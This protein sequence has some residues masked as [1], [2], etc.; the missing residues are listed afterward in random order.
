MITVHEPCRKKIIDKR[1]F[2]EKVDDRPK[3]RLRSSY[4]AE[5]VFNWKN[6]CFLCNKKADLRYSTVKKVETL[7]IKT[8]LLECSRERADKWG[9]EVHDRLNSCI[10]LVAEEA[11]Y[12]IVCMN[13]FRL[14]KFA[15][16]K[17]S[18]RPVDETQMENFQKVCQWLDEGDGELYTLAEIY[19]KMI[20]LSE[21]T[22]CY[23]RAYL[24]T[25][26][27]Q[28]YKDH[29]YFIQS[30]GRNDIIGFK[31]MSK[32]FMEE[33]MKMKER[34]PVDMI[35]A[36]AKIIKSDIREMPI[37]KTFYPS[38]IEIRNLDYQAEWV[39]DSL[40]LLLGQLF[41]SKLKQISIGQT[42][43]QASRPRSSIA[44]IPFG[45][46]VNL[47]KSFAT[48]WFVDHLAKFGFSVSSAEVKLFKESAIA[49]VSNDNTEPE[50]N[51]PTT[52]TSSEES[53]PASQ[54]PS[55]ESPPATQTPSEN[56]PPACKN[57]EVKSH[58][59]FQESLCT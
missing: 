18:G 33:F 1:S 23:H 39:P 59:N 57:K 24:K 40:Q 9:A 58:P 26:L 7:P 20:E 11:I 36:A 47:D 25:K 6:N 41:T 28:N 19:N 48:R 17:S 16:D 29:I 50:G 49:S 27:M 4:S 5:P 22:D 52:Q 42:I 34:T 53:P 56:I 15:K 38:L 46:G 8:R 35:R 37:D 13:R 14:M 10:D 51:P 3:K 45:I 2:P 44:P 21:G 43:I 31:Q 30:Q 54:T 12:H 55:E 32:F